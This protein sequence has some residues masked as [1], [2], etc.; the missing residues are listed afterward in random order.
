MSRE[1]L[2]EIARLEA[3]VS[4]LEARVAWLQRKNERL[5]REIREAKGM[6]PDNPPKVHVQPD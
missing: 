3:Q 2:T 1:L 5:L 6:D 4:D